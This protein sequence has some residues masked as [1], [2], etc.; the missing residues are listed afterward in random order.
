MRRTGR[1]HV[2]A[3]SSSSDEPGAE[4]G[5]SFAEA[6]GEDAARLRSFTPG[7]CY[8][9]PD[10]TG[11]GYFASNTSE[12]DEVPW[13]ESTDYVHVLI[14]GRGTGAEGIYSLKSRATESEGSPV[15]VIV[16]FECEDDACRFAVH[17]EAA[18]GRCPEPEAVDPQ[19]LLEFCVD[20]GHHCRFEPRHSMFLPA[21]TCL[22]MTDWERSNRLRG[23][24]FEVIGEEP[25]LNEGWGRSDEAQRLRERLEALLEGDGDD[26]DDKHQP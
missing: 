15:D 5:G 9:V 12:E 17:V 20:A 4:E 6:L 11:G 22:D 19:D 26:Q 24:H 13:W 23:G 3:S 1:R 21:E 14:F 7:G 25:A 16:A 10:A 18:M 2:R 8:F